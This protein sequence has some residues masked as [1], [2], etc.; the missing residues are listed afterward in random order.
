MSFGEIDVQTRQ[1][2]SKRVEILGY[3]L[4]FGL[5]RRFFLIRTFA[6]GIH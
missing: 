6:S 1:L 5:A 2:G 4:L 3:V